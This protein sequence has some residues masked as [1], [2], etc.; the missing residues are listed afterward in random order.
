MNQ[1]V[2]IQS[3]VFRDMTEGV[4]V[5]GENGKIIMTNP[6]LS[7]II[8][9][10][11]DEML[12]QHFASLFFDDEKNDAFAQTVLD[13][14][15]E[16]DV[17]HSNIVEYFCG[18]DSKYLSVITSGLYDD[19]RAT[20]GV[21]V[22]ISDVTELI[23]VRVRNT[24]IKRVLSN[25]L[26]D[27]VA[28]EVLNKEDGLK[29]GGKR[30]VITVLMSDLRGFSAMCTKIAPDD[31][32][33]LLN[34]Y[35]GKMGE[36]IREHSGTVIEYVGDGILAIFGAPISS[37]THAVDAVRA[38]LKMQEA[39]EEINSFNEENGLPKLQMGIG[40]NTGEAV[41][42]NMG[43]E[44]I[45][46][47]NVMGSS[48]NVCGRIE[49]YTVGGQIFISSTTIQNIPNKL[50]IEETID[51]HPKGVDEA[52]TIYSITGI[53]EPYNIHI[54]SSKTELKYYEIPVD[55]HMSILDGKDILDA[56]IPISILGKSCDEYIIRTSNPLEVF[57]NVLIYMETESVYC[58]VTKRSDKEENM[59]HLN[60]TSS[61]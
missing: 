25:Y 26:S 31:L 16:N 52:L 36:I 46:K 55:A 47:Y 33:V 9:K 60:I 20:T 13:A 32:M 22:V 24:F 50:D 54:K 58:K 30:E 37:N 45:M 8:G 43:S 41:V 51:I 6:R 56:K 17:V 35:L 39:M 57:T 3:R 4:M 34:N 28:D 15:Y 38:A 5:V 7:E 29:V 23:T 18:E 42:G 61:F 27:E 11:D 40:I 48:V 44:H 10:S 2:E 59:Y 14:I 49:S 19:E 1:T 12:D 21:I 53:D